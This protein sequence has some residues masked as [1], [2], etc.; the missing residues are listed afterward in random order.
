MVVSGEGR[1]TIKGEEK[2]ATMRVR[3]IIVASAEDSNLRYVL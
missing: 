1:L 2:F 3:A